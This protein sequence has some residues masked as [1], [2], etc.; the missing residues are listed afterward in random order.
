MYATLIDSWSAPLSLNGALNTAP[1]DARAAEVVLTRTNH[2][3]FNL[4]IQWLPGSAYIKR[5]SSTVED[6]LFALD[7]D[8]T[9]TFDSNVTAF[10]G[11]ASTLEDLFA[12]FPQGIS[13]NRQQ[14]FIGDGS[15]RSVQGVRTW[16]SNSPIA[17]DLRPTVSRLAF[18]ELAGKIYFGDYVAGGTQLRQVS[19]IDATVILD[20]SVRWNRAAAESIQA[21]LNY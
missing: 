4:T 17:S 18:F 6:R 9:P 7:W 20:Y 2:P 12:V 15:I 13:L 21:S 8:G 11:V 14:Y 10:P 1:T 3:L 16:V 5:K 19:S